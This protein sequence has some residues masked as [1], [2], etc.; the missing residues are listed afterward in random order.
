[1]NMNTN[2]NPQT[3][4]KKRRRIAARNRK[5]ENWLRAEGRAGFDGGSG[6]WGD[7]AADQSKPRA[8]QRE[9][10]RLRQQ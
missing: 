1:M 8:R 5:Q 2:T 3:K 10:Q 9:Q 4:E 7:Y 6:L